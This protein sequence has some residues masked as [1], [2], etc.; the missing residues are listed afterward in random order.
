[1]ERLEL[2]RIRFVTRHFKELQGLRQAPLGLCFAIIGILNFLDQAGF[3]LK[4]ALVVPLL[5][6]SA[7]CAFILPARAR[8]YYRQSFGEVERPMGSRSRVAGFVACILLGLALALAIGQSTV[9]SFF[10]LLFGLAWI[11][12]WIDMGARRFLAYRLGVGAFLV[13]LAIS[14]RPSALFLPGWGHPLT[15][16]GLE[17]F[18]MVLVGLLDHRLLV[19]GMG[20]LRRF[21]FD[22]RESAE[23]VA[24]R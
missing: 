5:A 6:L 3:E 22:A 1:M 24:Q 16:Q 12:S 2:D 14:G 8:S 23:P 17:G 13:L 10:C 21:S 9:S 15:V 20:G 7:A 4:M 19:R 18:C 11:G